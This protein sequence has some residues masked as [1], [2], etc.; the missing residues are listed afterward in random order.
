[1]MD[2]DNEMNDISV[3]AKWWIRM[4]ARYDLAR[5]RISTGTYEPV[6]DSDE[7]D[8][9]GFPVIFNS[10]YISEQLGK[11]TYF[12]M[13]QLFPKGHKYWLYNVHGGREAQKPAALSEAVAAICTQIRQRQ[14]EVAEIT[15][16][17]QTKMDN[18]KT[19]QKKYEL[20]REFHMVQ[21]CVNHALK[22]RSEFSLRIHPIKKEIMELNGQLVQLLEHDKAISLKVRGKIYRRIRYYCNYVWKLKNGYS[23]QYIKD[24]ILNQLGDTDPLEDNG[25]NLEKYLLLQDWFDEEFDE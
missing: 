7:V 22:L 11:Y 12:K 21:M 13:S 4:Q 17:E 20:S 19:E 2:E 1:M 18:L 23:T 16:D 14:A 8:P 15:K 25:I 24:E 9:S 6:N 3:I 5:N 10:P